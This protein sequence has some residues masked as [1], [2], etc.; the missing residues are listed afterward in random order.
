MRE[1]WLSPGFGLCFDGAEPAGEIAR[2]AE[3]MNW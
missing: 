3:P 2:R 1:G